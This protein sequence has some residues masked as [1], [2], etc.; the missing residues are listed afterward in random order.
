MCL[1]LNAAGIAVPPGDVPGS[2]AFS[3][4]RVGEGLIIPHR[5]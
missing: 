1:Q 4:A 2:R 3:G 5:R